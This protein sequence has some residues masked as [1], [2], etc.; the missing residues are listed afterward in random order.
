MDVRATTDAPAATGADTIAVGVF[1]GE[2]IAHDLPDGQLGALL[3]SGEARTG[4][5]KLALTHADGRRW[6]VAGLG[7]REEFDPERARIAAAGVLGRARELGTRSLCWELPH[8][9][10]D[11]HASAFVDGT[12]MGGYDFTLFKS[13]ADEDEGGSGELDELIVSAHHDVSE[14]VARGFVVAQSVNLARDLQNRPANDLT[15][16]ALAERAAEI[17]DRHD[18]LTLE[19]MGRTE[20]EAAGM[21]AF[22]GVAQGSE[23]EPKLITLRYEGPD[24]TGPVLGF[25]GK[26]VT[27]DSGGISLKPGMKMS[28]MK[29]DM[30]GGAAV[31]EATGAIARLGLP[32]PVVAVIGATENMPSGHALKPGDIVRARTG[33]TIEIINTDAEG[34]LV[35]ADCLA[36]AVELGAERLVDFATL[37]GAIVTTFGDTHAGLF[38]TDDAWCEAVAAAGKRAGELV[39]RMPLH[40][41]YAKAIEGR[42]AD[43]VNAVE[44]RKAGSIVAAEFLKRFTGDVPWAHLDIAGVAYENGRPYAPKGGSGFGVRLLIELAR[45]NTEAPTLH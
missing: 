28:E 41:D 9:L 11:A 14:P 23:E 1:D 30:S 42:Y 33:T 5:R 34:R 40:P 21:G 26:A 3:E 31:L 15:P 10:S 37:T 29:F 38:G 25:V 17:A 43:I 19:V 39:W 36:H 20:I 32:V 8:K 35:L 12:V 18:T 6:I 27:F 24:A 4:F 16:T 2:R 44:T 13:S 7:K 22:A 45:A